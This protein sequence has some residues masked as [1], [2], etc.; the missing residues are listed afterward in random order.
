VVPKNSKE[1]MFVIRKLM[2]SSSSSAS[3]TNIM[4]IRGVCGLGNEAVSVAM[5]SSMMSA[6]VVNAL[7]ACFNQSFEELS[8]STKFRRNVDHP[9]VPDH[10][11]FE[12]V[13]HTLTTTKS[14]IAMHPRFGRDHEKPSAPHALRGFAIA[15]RKLNASWLSEI[16]REGGIFGKLVPFSD[17]AVQIHTGDEIDERNISFHFDA[18]NSALHMALSVNGDRTLYVTYVEN[19]TATD[20]SRDLKYRQQV[21][22]VYISS[23]FA[24]CH[25][26]AYAASEW[27]DRVI[28]IQL[29]FSF[30]RNEWL[31]LRDVK[32]DMMRDEIERITAILARAEI[33]MPTLMDVDEAVMMDAE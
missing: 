17:A 3:S 31:Q 27:K 33:A 10:I 30:T 29:R 7:H 32:P 2:S 8:V 20:R 12:G 1:K 21:G 19:E 11:Y 6:D 14:I 16:C 26:V 18:V 13:F 9:E 15:F 24:F 28:A 25:G 22:S 4:P 23:P 5:R